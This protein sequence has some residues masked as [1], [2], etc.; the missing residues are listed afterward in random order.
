MLNG[1]LFIA[2]TFAHYIVGY[3]GP[4]NRLTRHLL[5]QHE[6]CAPPDGVVVI[7]HEMELVHIHTV[8]ELKQTMIALV[9]VVE[10]WDDPTLS[11]DPTNFSGLRVT[12]L[13]EEAIWVP[14]IIVFNMLNHQELLHSVRSPVRVQYTGRVTFSYPAIYSVMCRIGIAQFPFDSQTC[15][16]RIASWGYGEEKLRLNATRKPYLQ[17][18]SPNEEWALHN[19][20]IRQDHYDHEGVVVSEARYVVVIAR[21]PF[22]YLISLVLPSYIICM[23]S[24]AG[25]FARFSTKHERQERFTLGVTAILS[26][27]VLSLVVTEKVPHSSE[28]VPLLVVYFHYNIIMVTLATILTSIVMR[29]HSRGTAS[30]SS[31]PPKWLLR[32]LFIRK[33]EF[34]PPSVSG[35][36]N[37][38]NWTRQLVA[39]QWAEISRRMDYIMA[40][41]FLIIV[42]SPT[43]YLFVV[44]FLSEDVAQERALLAGSRESMHRV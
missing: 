24:I 30:K 42:T 4:S 32:Y 15:E 17:H 18:Y 27:A 20:S 41:V 7:T 5:K 39:E 14:D 16:L 10:E 11:W 37:A 33:A 28:G 19:V 35:G 44:C 8:D 6:K 40:L 1:V 22:Y 38:A 12:W 31:P 9:Y 43:V 3:Q 29:V 26:M 36:K 34:G 13:P 2:F 21:K 25:L 23:L